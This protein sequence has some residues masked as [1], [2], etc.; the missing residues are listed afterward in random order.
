[1]CVVFFFFF[2]FFVCLIL[3]CFVLSSVFCSQEDKTVH[4]ILEDKICKKEKGKR[5]NNCKT[6][7]A[8]YIDIKKHI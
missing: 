6:V 2:F 1:M 3:C 7:S 8:Y 5:T 4:V